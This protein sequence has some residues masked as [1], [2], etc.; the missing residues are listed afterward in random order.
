[1]MFLAMLVDDVTL[2]GIKSL[3]RC[4]IFIFRGVILKVIMRQSEYSKPS[5]AGKTIPAQPSVPC[6]GSRPGGLI[7]GSSLVRLA[8]HHRHFF[9]LTSLSTPTTKALL[10]PTDSCVANATDYYHARH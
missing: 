8:L 7:V 2:S 1:V 4:Y 6:E 10:L 5:D 3:F 9:S